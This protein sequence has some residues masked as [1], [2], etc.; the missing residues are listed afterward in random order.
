[1]VV[2]DFTWSLAAIDILVPRWGLR[3]E[4]VTPPLGALQAA[5]EQS[6]CCR[7][8]LSPCSKVASSG[9]KAKQTQSS[10]LARKDVA[11]QTEIP[12]N[13]VA[14]QASGCSECQSL[15]VMWD[16]GCVRCQLAGDLLCMVA[17]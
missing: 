15:L 17:A 12:R 9:P 6:E 3:P 11:T 7:A 8:E 16:D 14:L 5:G 2:A 13:R 4:R 1:M 10:L